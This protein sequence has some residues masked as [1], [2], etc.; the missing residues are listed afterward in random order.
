MTLFDLG[1]AFVKDIFSKESFL[2][3]Q[4]IKQSVTKKILAHKYNIHVD[5]KN[6]N[7]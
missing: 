4:Y 1:F 6:N 5:I 3:H 7:I 2:Q